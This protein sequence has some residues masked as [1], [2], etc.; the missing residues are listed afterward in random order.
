[1]TEGGPK[2]SGKRFIWILAVI[3]AVAIAVVL[4]WF[5]PQKLLMDDSIDEPIPGAAAGAGEDG[6]DVEV[7]SGDKDS[8]PSEEPKELATGNWTNLAHEVSGKARI[9][10]VPDGTRY[11]RF[12]DFEVEN[13]PDLRVY[14]SDASDGSYDTTFV[15]LGALKGN[16]GDQNYEIPD[17]IDIA[18]YDSAVIWC[19][20][21]SVGFAVAEMR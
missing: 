4:V 13:G 7:A 15:D 11:L 18:A 20:R 10:E 3:A 12:E 9:L 8:G 14:L 1:M 19:R 2:M 17:D 16:V 21:F 6:S 5:Q